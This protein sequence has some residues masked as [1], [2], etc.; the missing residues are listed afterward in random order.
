MA[1]A[2]VQYVVVR[3]DLITSLKWPVGAVIAQV[4]LLFLFYVWIC[5]VGYTY[6][7]INGCFQLVKW[8][9]FYWQIASIT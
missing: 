9:N 5:T 8:V 4:M 1:S 2:I 7:W 3:S 6:L